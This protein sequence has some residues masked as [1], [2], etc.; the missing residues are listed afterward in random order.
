M[1]GLMKVAVGLDPGLLRSAKLIRAGHTGKRLTIMFLRIQVRNRQ[2][3]RVGIETRR[4]KTTMASILQGWL[5]GFLPAVAPD[6]PPEDEGL[7]A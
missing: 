2:A 3:G 4:R 1:L 6:F 7:S 5:P